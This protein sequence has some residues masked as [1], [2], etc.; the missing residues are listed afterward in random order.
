MKDTDFQR[1]MMDGA[2]QRG[3]GGGG[4]GRSPTLSEIGYSPLGMMGGA[5]G[6]PAMGPGMGMHG[7]AMA[8]PAGIGYAGMPGVSPLGPGRFF[9][10]PTSCFKYEAQS[11][12]SNNQ[13]ESNLFN[14]LMCTGAAR[15]VTLRGTAQS[16]RTPKRATSAV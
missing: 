13:I 11:L 4:G 14:P 15:P 1:S 12:W 7:G 5:M 9:R 2:M 10:D 3:P 16:R 8:G 6:I